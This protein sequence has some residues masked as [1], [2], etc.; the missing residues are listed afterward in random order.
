MYGQWYLEVY[1]YCYAHLNIL[2][3]VSG[4]TRLTFKRC[5]KVIDM[6]GSLVDSCNVTIAITTFENLKG[7]KKLCA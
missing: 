6:I 2:I 5:S 3:A 4:I 1:K 7:S